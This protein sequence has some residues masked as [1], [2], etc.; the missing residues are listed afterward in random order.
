MLDQSQELSRNLSKITCYSFSSRWEKLLHIILM[1]VDK[2]HDV[3]VHLFAS[4]D[5]FTMNTKRKTDMHKI[6]S[7]IMTDH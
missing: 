5:A 6:C 7:P 1:W 3:N 2:S 4:T